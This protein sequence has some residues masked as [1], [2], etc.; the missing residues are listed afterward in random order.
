LCIWYRVYISNGM[1][2]R[3]LFVDDEPGTLLS[4]EA[5]FRKMFEVYTAISA[6]EALH[7][8]HELNS[9]KDPDKHICAI[10]SDHRM[11]VKNGVDLLSEIKKIFPTPERVILTAFGS[12]ELL[13]QAVKKADINYYLEKPMDIDK[14]VEIVSD[15]TATYSLRFRRQQL[16]QEIEERSGQLEQ[17]NKELGIINP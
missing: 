4:C 16:K 6:D 7:V 12:S 8:I 2:K 1:K 3:V 5:N 15:A 17:I 11:P 10:V 13:L 9:D 14:I